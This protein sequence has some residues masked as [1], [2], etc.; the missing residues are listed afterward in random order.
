M[1]R[2]I[3]DHPGRTATSD[4]AQPPSAV[5]AGGRDARS[6]F[7]EQNHNLE[8]FVRRY[9]RTE[10]ELRLICALGERPTKGFSLDEL[11][12][13]AGGSPAGMGTAV[14]SLEHEGIVV[15]RRQGRRLVATLAKSP[16]VREMGV[17]LFRLSQREQER[18]LLLHMVTDSYTD[19]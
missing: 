2:D 19:G 10:D 13:L 1:N 8:M 9:L 11:S 3:T 6:D 14:I 15:T 12:A 18:S 17:R 16:E 4:P 5:T 7:W